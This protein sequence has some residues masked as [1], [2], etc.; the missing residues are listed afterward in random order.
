[1]TGKF[2]HQHILDSLSEPVLIITTDY[3]IADVN[4][5]FCQRFGVDRDAA[6]GDLC[7]RITHDA[8]DPYCGMGP[9]CPLVRALESGHQARKMHRQPRGRDTRRWEEVVVTPF[10]GDDGNTYVLEEIRDVQELLETREVAQELA[11]NLKLLSGILPICAEC[12]KIRDES[13]RWHDLERYVHDHAGTNFS[14]GIC[15]DCVREVYP[16]Y[17]LE[18]ESEDND[19]GAGAPRDY[20]AAIRSEIRYIV[21]NQTDATGWFQQGVHLLHA[22]SLDQAE[23]VFKELVVALPSEPDGYEGLAMLYRTRG[24]KE[25]ALF[26]IEA[27]ITRAR[28]RVGDGTAEP[29]RVEEL[30]EEQIQIREL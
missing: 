4:E 6:V 21:P 30:R 29:D 28:K 16:D 24:E 10:R 12:R 2:N 27:A 20:L 18:D 17:D 11:D 13:G 25:K 14:H 5:A 15:P 26:F 8:D 1:M 9:A 19:T 7:Y 23:V 3:R 22:G